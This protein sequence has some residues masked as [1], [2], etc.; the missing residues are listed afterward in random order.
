[1]RTPITLVDEHITVTNSNLEAIAFRWAES[2]AIRTGESPNSLLRWVRETSDL[3]DPDFFNPDS[4]HYLGPVGP[5][6]LF[7]QLTDHFNAE[8]PTPLPND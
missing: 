2:I 6:S 5:S 7:E 1:M 8:A 3:L 4:A